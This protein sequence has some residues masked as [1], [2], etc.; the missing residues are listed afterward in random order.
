MVQDL[1]LLS[2][3][4]ALHQLVYLKIGK[5]LWIITVIVVS[6][7]CHSFSLANQTDEISFFL[8]KLKMLD[9]SIFIT[10]SSSL[11]FA[12]FK[13]RLLLGWNLHNKL[14]NALLITQK[15]T[16]VLTNSITRKILN[17]YMSGGAH[18]KYVEKPWPR[19]FS[20]FYQH[21]PRAL[22]NKTI[23][24]D[25]FPTF[26]QPTHCDPEMNIVEDPWWQIW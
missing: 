12:S 26:S 20:A 6:F 8:L 17:I 2:Y 24:W 22:Y 5:N 15:N 19:H 25:A 10:Y 13:S 11:I 23:N 16:Q 9:L 3:C 21:A 18:N 1:T 4:I 14:I 7:L